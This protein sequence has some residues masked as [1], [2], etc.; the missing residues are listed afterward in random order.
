MQSLASAPN[1]VRESDGNFSWMQTVTGDIEDFNRWSHSLVI[2]MVRSTKLALHIVD[3]SAVYSFFG[4]IGGAY[5][6]LTLCYGLLCSVKSPEIETEFAFP[7][8]WAVKWLLG[9]GLN[10][11]CKQCQVWPFRLSKSQNLR[12]GV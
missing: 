7:G 5:T 1:Y 4:N 9:G 12:A 8:V 3:V 6:L 11:V 10:K 2:S